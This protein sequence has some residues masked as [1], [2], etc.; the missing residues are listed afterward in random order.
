MHFILM[1][2]LSQFGNYFLLGY[3][4]TLIKIK[5]LKFLS[6]RSSFRFVKA[7]SA[8]VHYRR[9]LVDMPMHLYNS[10][11]CDRIHVENMPM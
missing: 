3:T 1:F 2:L 8:L 10:I 11:I 9:A 6:V 5:Q 4:T 7:T